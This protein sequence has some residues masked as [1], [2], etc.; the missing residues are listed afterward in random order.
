MMYGFSN[1]GKEKL[2]FTPFCG[3]PKLGCS[4]GLCTGTIERHNFFCFRSYPGEIS[5]LNSPYGE[6]SNDV[7]D[8]VEL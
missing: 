2:Q 4:Y 3:G 8:M 5:H 1:G 6:L 7:S